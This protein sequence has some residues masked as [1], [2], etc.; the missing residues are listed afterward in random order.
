MLKSNVVHAAH[1]M[2]NHLITF[3]DA[4]HTRGKIFALVEA[5]ERSGM[6]SRYQIYYDDLYVKDGSAWLFAERIIR[7]TFE[8]EIL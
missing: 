5:V 4:N 8:P 1:L 2:F 3:D 7:K 6:R